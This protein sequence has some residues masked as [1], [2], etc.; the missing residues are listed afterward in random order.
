MGETFKGIPGKRWRKRGMA[1]T[2]AVIGKCVA[3]AP[4]RPNKDEN[5]RLID[6]AIAN[7]IKIKR[8]PTGPKLKERKE[9]RVGARCSGRMRP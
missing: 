4:F 6:E 2:D 9:H 3:D 8:Y 7:G 5:R 1:F